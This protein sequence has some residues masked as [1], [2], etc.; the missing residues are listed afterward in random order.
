MKKDQLPTLLRIMSILI[1][2]GVLPISL[3]GQKSAESVT[4]VFP[5]GIEFTVPSGMKVAASP[6][7][8]EFRGISFNESV[9][10]TT[11]PNIML[12]SK[13]SDTLNLRQDTVIDVDFEE[14]GTARC[15]DLISDSSTL[16]STEAELKNQVRS[17]LRVLKRSMTEWMGANDRTLSGNPGKCLVY[18]WTDTTEL[19]SITRSCFYSF[20]D[21]RFNYVISFPKKG[22]D[23]AER[24]VDEFERSINIP[25][26]I[27]R[28]L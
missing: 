15:G 17:D 13:T 14:C 12:A 22:R 9:L 27:G 18:G 6:P 7:K 24:Q 28:K 5:N 19:I 26:L 11:S 10:R 21:S 23:L 2:A 16:N 4:V 1:F 8:S 25:S 20:G 3:W